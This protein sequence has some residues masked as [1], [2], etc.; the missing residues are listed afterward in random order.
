MTGRQDSGS[1]PNVPDFSRL[2]ASYDR[3]RPVDE[4]WWELFDLV[5]READLEGRRV[6]DVG[7]GTGRLE[8]ALGGRARVWGIDPEPKMLDV[9]RRNAPEATFKLGRAESLP[10]KD[11]WFE[12]AVM[13]LSAHLV[14]RSVAFAEVRR[15]LGA[16]GR[17]AVATFDPSYFDV[18]WLNT[19]FPSME[20]VDRARFPTAEGL[21]AE[22]GGAG[23]AEVRLIRLSQN[24]SHPREEGLARIRKGHISTFD[25]ISREEYEEGLARAERELPER[26][27]YRVEWLVAVADAAVRGVG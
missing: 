13:W 12:R 18:F 19:F 1:S 5:E 4:K 6:L 21:E 11:G 15:V 26:I 9:A 24:A 17:F 23:F 22:L 7:C 25:L 20:A 3:V 2:A 14:D 8:V 16:D 10:F 27:D